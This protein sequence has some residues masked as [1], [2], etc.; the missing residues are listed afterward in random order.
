MIAATL[1]A[2]PLVLLA[3]TSLTA[4]DGS[5]PLTLEVTAGTGQLTVQLGDLLRDPG[6][7]QAVLSGVPLR[8]HVVAELWQDR[9]F[10]SERG[11]AEWRATIIH[12]PLAHAFLVEA[13]TQEGAR[14][15]PTLEDASTVLQSILE[16]PLEP[17]SERGRYYYLANVEIETLSLSD[18]EELQRWLRGDLAPVVTEGEDVEGAMARG[19]RRLVVRVLGLPAR[20]F[21]VRTPTFDVGP[22]PS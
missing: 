3:A 7:G 18:L 6:L 1:R 2:F 16:I 10:D 12:E 5:P 15:V 11:R 13:S 9:L 4:Q 17:P 8:I 22:P 14:V 20:R 19:V 21:R